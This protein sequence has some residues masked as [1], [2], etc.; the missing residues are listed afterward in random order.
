MAVTADRLVIIGRGRL[1]TQTPMADFL[2]AGY[3]GP[4]MVRSPQAA[5]LAARLAARGATIARHD[6]DTLAVTG[7]TPEEIGELAR[8]DGLTSPG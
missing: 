2:A 4:V 3:G 8:A 7:T 6:G 1:I 5:E